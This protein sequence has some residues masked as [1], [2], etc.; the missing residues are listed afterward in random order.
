[1]RILS[2][3]AALTVSTTFW[4]LP[5]ASHA[6]AILV[7]DGSPCCDRSNFSGTVGTRFLVGTDDIVINALG[8]EDKGL[9]GL[10]STHE[11]GI[12]KRSDE[13]LLASVTVSAGTGSDLEDVW[14]YEFIAGGPL[15]L[16]AGIEYVIGA[17][18]ISG[19]DAFTDSGGG[20]AEFSFGTG[21][22][23]GAG[24]DNAAGSPG[25]LFPEMTTATLQICAGAPRTHSS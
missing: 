13:M 15:T 1:M 4:A 10:A 3:L 8:F 7:S 9:D 18:L 14:R 21:V 2:F 16:L 25:F 5:A 12:W 6:T 24:S 20:V 19:G 11:V 23:G 17:Q 22:S